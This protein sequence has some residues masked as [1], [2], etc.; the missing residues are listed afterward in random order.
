[1]SIVCNEA[2]NLLRRYSRS[3]A[4]SAKRVLLNAGVSILLNNGKFTMALF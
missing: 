3:F 1:M 4:A 2:F